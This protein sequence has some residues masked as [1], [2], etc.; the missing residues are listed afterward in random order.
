MG[1]LNTWFEGIK[2]RMQEAGISQEKLAKEMNRKPTQ[3]S[4]WFRRK[5]ATLAS[6]QLIDNS[7]TA[8]EQRKSNGN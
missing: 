2:A 6:M 1:N 8:L 4:R 3:V 7:L 5:T